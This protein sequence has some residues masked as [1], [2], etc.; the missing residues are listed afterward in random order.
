MG[1]CSVRRR[2]RWRN[3][4]PIITWI[5]R[6]VRRNN[7]K[8]CF[9][10]HSHSFGCL[11]RVYLRCIYYIIAHYEVWMLFST[12]HAFNYHCH[13]FP[14]VRWLTWFFLVA[15]ALFAKGTDPNQSADA[16]KST[17]PKNANRTDPTNSCVI[18]RF[19]WQRC[20]LFH[21]SGADFYVNLVDNIEIK[22]I[23][24][25]QLKA[26]NKI[27]IY[28]TRRSRLPTSSHQHPHSTRHPKQVWNPKQVQTWTDIL[29][30]PI[31]YASQHY[32]IWKY[33]YSC[34]FTICVL[35]AAV[36]RRLSAT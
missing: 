22:F 19:S 35:F 26:K 7:C 36:T 21:F 1:A 11:L 12:W 9:L 6:N 20:I 2:Q 17:H 33:K 31:R 14:L 13:L 25:K 5:S 24:T 15:S 27:K 30:H 34:R 23:S 8:R 32:F 3:K 4:A 10:L 28:I 29:P 16:I 18:E